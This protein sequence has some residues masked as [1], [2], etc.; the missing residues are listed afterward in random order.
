MKPISEARL[1]ANRANARKS[2]G[3]T[4]PEGKAISSKNRLS[5]GFNS[6]MPCM[7]D[8]DPE[9][10]ERLRAELHN[11][12]RPATATQTILV[13]KMVLSHWHYLRATRVINNL[14]LDD[15]RPQALA[16]AMRY[17]TSNH[18]A[19]HKALAELQK[20]KAQR[21]QEVTPADPPLDGFVPQN[22]PEA[23]A[24]PHTCVPAA[25]QPVSP[26]A[27][28]EKQASRAASID[29]LLKKYLAVA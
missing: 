29:A 23:D 7:N 14:I 16:L 6:A 24:A 25:S 22:R 26:A 20:L 17:Q 15:R 19:F 1:A 4:S 8:E 12:H 18:N 28:P 11:E 9:E 21:P 27:K 5:F 2:T 10:F 13:D 3:P